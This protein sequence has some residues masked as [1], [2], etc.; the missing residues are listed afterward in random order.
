MFLVYLTGLLKINENLVM[1]P[2]FPNEFNALVKMK[3][4]PPGGHI[5]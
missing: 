5:T 4:T 1:G 2:Q 3:L